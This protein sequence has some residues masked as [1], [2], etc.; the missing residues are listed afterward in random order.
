MSDIDFYYDIVCPYAYLGALQIEERLKKTDSQV[1]WKPILLGGLFRY[2]Q[3]PDVPAQTW[4]VSKARY[5]IMDLARQAQKQGKEFRYHPRHPLRTVEA[6]RMIS[7]LPIEDTARVSLRIFSAYWE[8]GKDISDPNIIN[9]IAQE[10]GVEQNLFLAPQAKERL[11]SQTKEAHVRGV[12]GVPTF[13]NNE[14]IWWGQDRIHLVE[15]AVGAAKK[16]FPKGK[17]KPSEVEFFHDFSSPFSYLGAM[18][19]PLLEQRYD[20]SIALRPILLGA[21]FRNIGTP[22]VPLF[23]MSK[24]KQKYMLRDL[25][26]WSQFW[27]VPFSFPSKFPIRSILPLRISILAPE[28]TYDIYQAMWSKGEDISNPEVLKTIIKEKGLDWERLMNDL[29]KAKEILKKNTA[30]AEKIGVCGVPS[31]VCENKIWWG[32]DRIHD[33]VSTV[34]G[35]EESREET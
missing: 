27:N 6:M 29:P 35:N 31:F 26:D 34:F 2:N 17:T 19:V 11:F 18:Q 25:H 8:E 15:H 21:L 28:C 12:F 20:I 32:Q 4:A 14:R 23:A 16:T 24:P 5:G 13:S 22:D 10:L 3:S 30:E 9:E 33:F 1:H 7:M